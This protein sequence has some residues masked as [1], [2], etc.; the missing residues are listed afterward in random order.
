M[1]KMVSGILFLMK[2]RVTVVE[3]ALK[4]RFGIMHDRL[5]LT[6]F[7]REG[8]IFEFLARQPATRR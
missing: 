8:E 5:A 6:A 3:A 1:K 4:E 2:K 7:L